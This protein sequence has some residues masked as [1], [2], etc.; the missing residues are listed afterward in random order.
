M[1]MSIPSWEMTRFYIT[2]EAGN[3]PSFATKICQLV[4][5]EGKR[6]RRSRL[7]RLLENS[8]TVYSS[9]RYFQSFPATHS[10]L[11][12]FDHTFNINMQ[13]HHHLLLFTILYN[14]LEQPKPRDSLRERWA[15]SVQVF[16]WSS[17]NMA[18]TVPSHLQ[19]WKED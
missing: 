4:R 10:Y 6:E 2:T 11:R 7:W 19:L 14:Y 8:I 5:R 3:E 13:P 15:Y 17:G 16:S 1:S 18:C 12:F 9:T